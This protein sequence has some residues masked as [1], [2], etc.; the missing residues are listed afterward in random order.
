MLDPNNEFIIDAVAHPY[1]DSPENYRDPEPAA[2]ICDMAF[3]FNTGSSNPACVVPHD[4]YIS[5]WSVED[6]ANVLF[7]PRPGLEAFCEYL[8]PEDLLEERGLLAPIEQ[9][10]HDHKRNILAGNW[11]R[12]HGLDIEATKKGIA[13]DEFSR[14]RRQDPKSQPWSTTS[15]WSQIEEERRNGNP[16]FAHDVAEIPAS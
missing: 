10:S 1:N 6:A 4:A 14:A 7:R 12:L 11:A 16:A 15:E 3:G 8:T 9:I 5:D 13:D 2:M